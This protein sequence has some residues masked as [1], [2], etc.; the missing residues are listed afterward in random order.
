MNTDDGRIYDQEQM[1]ELHKLFK[2]GEMT[3]EQYGKFK[4]MAIYPTM[5]QLVRNP[6]RVGRNEPCPCGSGLKFKNCCYTGPK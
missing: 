1:L 3:A 6:A 5:P 4:E 2:R